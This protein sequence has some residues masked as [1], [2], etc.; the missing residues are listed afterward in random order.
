MHRS[1]TCTKML[2]AA[3]KTRL[4]NGSGKD[5]SPSRHGDGG[6]GRHATNPPVSLVDVLLQPPEHAFATG[7]G[8]GRE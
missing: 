6:G 4:G 7:Q 5:S 2:K 8:G 3:K 1:W